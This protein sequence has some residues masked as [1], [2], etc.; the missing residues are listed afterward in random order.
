MGVRATAGG[1]GVPPGEKGHRGVFTGV[2]VYI[3]LQRV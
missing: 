1:M 2:G 3:Y